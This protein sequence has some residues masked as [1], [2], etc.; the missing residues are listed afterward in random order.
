MDSERKNIS[1]GEK[2]QAK[3]LWQELTCHVPSTAR[4]PDCRQSVV[5][6]TFTL[7]KN[8][9]QECCHLDPAGSVEQ[10]LKRG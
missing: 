5:I 2:R 9:E 6:L 7:S 10:S 3:T 8:L 1:G 4:R